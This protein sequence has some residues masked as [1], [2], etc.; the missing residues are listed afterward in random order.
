MMCAGCCTATAGW[1]GLASADMNKDIMGSSVVV[2]RGCDRA[3]LAVCVGE[4]PGGRR[5]WRAPT[6]RAGRA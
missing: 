5:R 3:C 1:R 4:R 6:W 2:R